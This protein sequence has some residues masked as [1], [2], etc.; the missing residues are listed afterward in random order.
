MHLITYPT[1]KPSS[2][3]ATIKISILIMIDIWHI[4]NIITLIKIMI[5]P[6]SVLLCPLAYLA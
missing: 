3:T 1:W 5:V 2:S 6:T 4:I